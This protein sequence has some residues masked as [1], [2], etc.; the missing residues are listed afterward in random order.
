MKFMLSLAAEVTRAVV[1]AVLISLGL[2]W[3][4]QARRSWRN[5]QREKGPAG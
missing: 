5:R 1:Y 2:R 4:A 3:I